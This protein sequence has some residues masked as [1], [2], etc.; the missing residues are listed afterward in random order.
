MTTQ[1]LD[2][3]LK[4][5]MWH[6]QELLKKRSY[7]DDHIDLANSI[8]EIIKINNEISKIDIE[9]DNYNYYLF[10]ERYIN[11][12]LELINKI[13][14][15]NISEYDYQ[16]KEYI[17]MDFSDINRYNNKLMQVEYYCI[18][19][20]LAQRNSLNMIKRSINNYYADDY[21]YYFN[22]L[23]DENNGLVVDFRYY[24][25]Q[26]YE[27][28]PKILLKKQVFAN[29]FPYISEFLDKLFKYRLEIECK[30]IEEDTVKEIMNKIFLKYRKDSEE[31]SKE[32]KLFIHNLIKNL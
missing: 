8:T 24:S 17:I 13:E 23:I 27:P 25:I 28:N 15:N 32:K 6:K 16:S 20:V 29:R 9:L 3:K 2:E 10:D 26:S 12:V 21:D 30:D 18:T 11:Y 7:Y 22:N 4:E 1:Q 14:N 31:M 19:F 5:L